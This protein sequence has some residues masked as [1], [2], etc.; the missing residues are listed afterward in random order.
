MSAVNRIIVI[1]NVNLNSSGFPTYSYFL[2]SGG[3]ADTV[4]VRTGDQIAWVVTVIDGHKQ[5]TP[6]YTL[7]FSDPTVFGTSSLSVASGGF[8]SFLQV[9]TLAI[10]SP[11]GTMK[12]S[13]SVS[14]ISPISDPLIQIDDDLRPVTPAAAPDHYQVRWQPGPP[15]AMTFSKNKGPFDPFPNPLTV[16][17]G[18]DVTFLVT[19]A[20]GFDVLFQV[21]GNH[22]PPFTPF[23]SGTTDLPGTKVT[24]GSESTDTYTVR[25]VNDPD[26][27]FTFSVVPNNS[28]PS[29]HFVIAVSQ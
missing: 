2:K 19:P 21:S 23:T 8:S 27:N 14:G 13:L 16:H 17:P 5:R 25:T 11:S 22:F 7:T 9:E 26:P 12:Y 24:D 1:V 6:A 18:D 4:I 10:S 28:A 15:A 20:N 3:K 29:G